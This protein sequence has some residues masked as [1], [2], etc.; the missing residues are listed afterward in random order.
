MPR[1]D[2]L[3]MCRAI[4]EDPDLAGVPVVLITAYLPPRDP[5]LSTAGAT[6]VVRK[7]FTL[8]ELTMA[9]RTTWTGPDRPAGVPRAPR[10]R[11]WRTPTVRRRAGRSWTR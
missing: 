3:Q 7:P 10:G 9:V 1:L 11:T 2:G 4:R 8:P 6:A 5:Q